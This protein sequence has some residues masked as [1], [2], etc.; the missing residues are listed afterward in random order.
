MTSQARDFV[1]YGKDVP[2]VRWPNDAKLALTFAVNYEAGGERSA[3]Y[4]ESPETYGE[5]PAYGSP[6]RR[7]L[8]IESIFEYE[9]RVAIWRVLRLFRKHRT[10][11]TFFAS[12]RTL[13]VNDEATKEI[14][15]NG[16]EICSHGY[17]WIESFTLS[18]RAER[19][20]IKKAVSTIKKLTGQRP[21]GWY[22]RE[23]SE[24]TIELLVEEGGFLYDSDS[25]SDDL[26]YYVRVKGKNFLIIPYTPDI[27][28]FHFFSNRFSNSEQFFQYMVDSFN[29]LYEEGTQNPKLMNVGIH[30]RISGR[31]GRI[32][33]LDRFLDYL[34]KK[35]GVWIAPRID[36]AKW[37]LSSYKSPI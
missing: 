12:A 25:Y 3:F 36:I 30:V 19:E 37:W 26:P 6:P 35:P 14:V 22:C 31:P 16:H 18:R 33:A 4:G 11:V 20:Q 21:L 9:T 5:F 13:E 32:V 17:R 34:E 29:T 2:R 8:A 7:D 27:N 15:K 1:G 10:K 23:P 28:D 24:N